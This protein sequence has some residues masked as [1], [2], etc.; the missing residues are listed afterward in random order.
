M[1]GAPAATLC[2]AK[3]MSFVVASCQEIATYLHAG[4]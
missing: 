3:D 2:K 4:L 1:V